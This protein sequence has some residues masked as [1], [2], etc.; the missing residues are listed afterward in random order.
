MVNVS[1]LT[2]PFTLQRDF[3]TQ[4]L[5]FDERVPLNEFQTPCPELYPKSLLISKKNSFKMVIQGTIHVC[6]PNVVIFGIMIASLI[7]R[8]TL[9]TFKARPRLVLDAKMIV[10]RAPK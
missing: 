10:L 2:S 6:R 7:R 3:G 8:L 1:N 5:E 9:V 4:C